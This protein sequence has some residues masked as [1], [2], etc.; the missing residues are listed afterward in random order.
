MTGISTVVLGGLGKALSNIQRQY[1]LDGIQGWVTL[2]LMQWPMQQETYDGKNSYQK[3]S[4]IV[5]T[6]EPL[7]LIA[8][9]LLKCTE[10]SGTEKG[11]I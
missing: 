6:S 10:I 7:T 11:F 8:Q 9:T 5:D 1:H 4:E 2:C 3:Y